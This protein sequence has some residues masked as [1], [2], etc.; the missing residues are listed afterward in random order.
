MLFNALGRAIGLAA[1]LNKGKG[2]VGAFRTIGNIADTATTGA[3]LYG[4]SQLPGSMRDEILTEGPND[5]Y[6]TKDPTAFKLSLPQ[7]AVFGLNNLISGPFG[8]KQITKESLSE[9][10]RNRNRKDILEDSTNRQLMI[11][12]GIKSGDIGKDIYSQAQLDEFLIPKVKE[13]KVRKNLAQKARSYNIAVTPDDTVESLQQKINA[14][15]L[16]PIGQ[17]NTTQA[18]QQE[19]REFV[20]RA[21]QDKI[22]QLNKTRTQELEL[23]L[24]KLGNESARDERSN[25]LALM[26]LQNLEQKYARDARREERRDQQQLYATLLQ[27]LKNIRL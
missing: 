8:G 22:D 7:Q 13:A 19:E 10:Y 3:L 2:A 11:E 21:Y 16:S 9:D 6:N 15:P 27:S 25:K 4:A 17:Y 18:L 20:R 5:P 26:Q 24:A 12:A 1:K 23:A 14:S